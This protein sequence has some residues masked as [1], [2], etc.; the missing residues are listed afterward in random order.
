MEDRVH[1]SCYR[2][3]MDNVVFDESES[4]K[5]GK[6]GDVLSPAG[7]EVVDRN[8]FPTSSTQGGTKMKSEESAPTRDHGARHQ[9]PTPW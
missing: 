6:V 1:R 7:E 5:T 9:R 8:N 4:G 2:Y 3:S